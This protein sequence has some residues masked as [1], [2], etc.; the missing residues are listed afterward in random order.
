MPNNP[1]RA[2]F[3]QVG[4]AALVGLSLTGGAVVVRRKRSKQASSNPINQ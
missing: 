4:L 2:V 1:L 3:L